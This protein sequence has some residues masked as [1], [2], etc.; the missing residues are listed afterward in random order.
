MKKIIISLFSI[1]CLGGTILFFSGC[2]KDF[3]E[4]NQD[5][6]ALTTDDLKSDYRLI[7]EPFV[8]MVRNIYVLTPAWV[9]QLQQNLIGDVYS[10]YMM[11]PTPFAGNSNNMNYNLVDGWN[12]WA[13]NPSYTSVMAATLSVQQNAGSDFP[14]FLAW[15]QIIKVEAMHRV[16][17][18]FGPIIYT[19]YGQAEADGSFKYDCQDV[20]YDQFFKDLDAG[21]AGLDTYRAAHPGATPFKSF[22]EVYAGNVESWIRFANSLRLRLAIRIS[23]VDAGRAKSEGEKAMNHPL[24]VITTNAEN[25][26]VKSGV[27]HPM[28]TINNAWNDIRMGAPMESIL[29]GY[30]DPRLAKYF[31]TSIKV[32]GAYKG[33][34]QGIEIADKGAYVTFSP[35]QPLG[36]VQLMVAAETYF[37]RAEGVLRGWSNMG[38]TAQELYEQ[39]ITTSFT[40]YGSEGA[41]ASYIADNISRPVPY[42]DPNNAVNDVDA[43]DP[44]LSQVTIAWNEGAGFETKIEKIITQKWISMFP[45]GQ[46]AWSEFRRTGY[47]KLFPVVIN[48]SG[49]TVDTEQQIKRIKYI[50]GEYTQNPG[51]VASGISCLGGPDTGGTPL[52]WDID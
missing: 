49:G 35:L 38:G 36:D 5:P 15:M 13:W 40:Q 41:A 6:F 52:W 12:T 29:V 9:T 3:E 31:Q 37:L 45:D 19:K 50:S 16:T 2:N 51:G 11:P 17:D 22:D 10:G 28:N 32:P 30:N 18:M 48:N 47:P 43:G 27:D 1:I 42:V 4:F 33:I 20:V 34:R 7:G 8:S 39:G 26:T 44:H 23:R 46:E 14:E 21:I 24:G 25:F